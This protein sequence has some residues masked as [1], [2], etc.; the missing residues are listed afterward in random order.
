MTDST[1]P[2]VDVLIAAEMRL[3]RE[4]LAM[5][6]IDVGGLRVRATAASASELLRECGRVDPSLVLLDMAVP[7]ALEAAATLRLAHPKM[8]IVALGMHGEDQ[9]VACAEVGIA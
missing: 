5:A 1:A 9:V 8:R 2:T 7:G 6:L 3:Y 4:G